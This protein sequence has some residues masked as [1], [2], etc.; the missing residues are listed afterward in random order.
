MSPI[1]YMFYNANLLD[2]PANE[3]GNGIQ[4]LGF[5][6]DIAY[7]VQGQSDAENVET[8]QRML[9]N[10]EQWRTSHGA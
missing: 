7:G 2:I 10:A 9:E 1:L 3:Q 5:I 6:D 8:L 4:S